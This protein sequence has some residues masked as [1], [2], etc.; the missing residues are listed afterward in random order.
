MLSLGP[1]EIAITIGALLLVTFGPVVAGAVVAFV[2]R[3][4]KGRAKKEPER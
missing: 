2:R 1:Y 3:L 4:R